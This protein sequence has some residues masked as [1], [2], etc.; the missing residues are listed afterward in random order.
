MQEDQFDADAQWE[1]LVKGILKA[2][3][4]RRD[5]TYADLVIDLRAIG[6][7]ETETNIKNKLSRGRFSAIFFVQCLTAIGVPFLH[8]DETPKHYS[9]ASP[10]ERARL[11][12]MMK[13]DS[14]REG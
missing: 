2:E 13:R 5:K 4:R 14:A 3:L 1:G 6:V 10:Q 8:L 12:F 7:I 9:P 11:K